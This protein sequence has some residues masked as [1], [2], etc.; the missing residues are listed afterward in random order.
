MKNNGWMAIRIFGLI[1]FLLSVVVHASGVEKTVQELVAQG[2]ALY[3]K[4]DFQDA[5][6]VYREAFLH[7][8][9]DP[10]KAKLHYNLGN[11]HYRLGELE[12]A[13]KEYQEALRLNPDDNDAKFNLEVVMRALQG[14]RGVLKGGPSEI[15]KG[16]EQQALSEEIKLLL[17]RLEQS[18]FS[19]DPK[20]IP[21]PPSGEEKPKEYKKD[22]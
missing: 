17:Q 7:H 13:L 5:I 2:N 10:D 12:K 20:G 14:K 8:L 15:E 21:Q 4:G 1:I 22:W 6:K 19:R 11:S 9:E 3:L 18:D 16:A